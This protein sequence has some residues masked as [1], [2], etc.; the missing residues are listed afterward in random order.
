MNNG[1]PSA[2]YFPHILHQKAGAS[3][4][5]M[6]KNPE[7]FLCYVS[8]V[9]PRPCIIK[10]TQHC[11]CG[12]KERRGD[13]GSLTQTG[14]NLLIAS[15]QSTSAAEE[16]V[17][18]ESAIVYCGERFLLIQQH[19]RQTWQDKHGLMKSSGPLL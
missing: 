5:D 7:K 19:G 18:L 3:S 12:K 4:M 15:V 6:L 2:D 8:G 1:L 10:G 16:W 11:E 17:N 9:S 14:R 13:G